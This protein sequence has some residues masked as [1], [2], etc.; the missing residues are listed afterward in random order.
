MDSGHGDVSWLM[1]PLWS[2][3]V[4]NN[5]PVPTD[6]EVKE[7]KKTALLP[8]CVIIQ[9]SYCQ[10]RVLANSAWKQI[11]ICSALLKKARSELTHYLDGF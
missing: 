11:A 6:S 2:F 5:F 8:K 10:E 4:E 1:E 9:P 7:K 3:I